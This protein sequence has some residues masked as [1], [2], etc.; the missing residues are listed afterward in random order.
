MLQSK[1]AIERAVGGITF[2]QLGRS[3]VWDSESHRRD[4]EAQNENG[5]GERHAYTV[6]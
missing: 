2:G 6:L 3:L 1:L 4:D 5:K